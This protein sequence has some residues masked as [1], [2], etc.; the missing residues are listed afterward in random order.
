MISQDVS[1]F[2]LSHSNP[3][4]QPRQTSR[5]ERDVLTGRYRSLDSMLCTCVRAL[6]ARVK[7]TQYLSVLLFE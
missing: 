1:A 2:L 3:R 7:C 5:A 4:R 6:E